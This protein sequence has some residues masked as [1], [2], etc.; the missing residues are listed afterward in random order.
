[1]ATKIPTNVR[2]LFGPPTENECSPEVLETARVVAKEVDSVYTPNYD[3]HYGMG[4]CSVLW[5]SRHR[6]LEVVISADGQRVDFEGRN[7]DDTNYIQ[8]HCPITQE[9]EFLGRWLDD[10]S[11]E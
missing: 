4:Q 9:F 7:T 11:D 1:M 10:Q 6:I 5:Q 8:G 2:F 3:S